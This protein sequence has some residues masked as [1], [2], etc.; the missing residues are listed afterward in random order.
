M[1]LHHTK[2]KDNY[3]RFI[4]S[5]IETDINDKPITKYSDKVDY[6]FKRFYSEYGFM[7]PK[8]GKQKAISE[9]LSGLALDLPFYYNDIVELAI[10]M[11][12]INPNP[13]NR[14]RNKVE[15]GYWDF[16]SNI[17]LEIEKDIL[18]QQKKSEV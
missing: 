8:V 15:Q 6:L 18:K 4:L 13:S 5:T 3:K 9:W 16:M 17:I 14:L 7:I 1:K 12:S 2:Y 11:G 10:K